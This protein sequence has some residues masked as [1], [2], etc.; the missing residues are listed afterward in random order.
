MSAAIREKS[1]GCTSTNFLKCLDAIS[2]LQESETGF[3]MADRKCSGGLLSF[4][5]SALHCCHV[6][7]L[8][9]FSNDCYNWAGWVVN[10]EILSTC[11]LKHIAH[12]ALWMRGNVRFSSRGSPKAALGG[13]LGQSPILWA[14]LDSSVFIFKG[15]VFPQVYFVQIIKRWSLETQPICWEFVISIFTRDFCTRSVSTCLWSYIVILCLFY[16]HQT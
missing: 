8:V 1:L 16:V 9:L 4:F 15:K 3:V 12:P 2:R 11:F 6:L 10:T 14:C 13:S 5:F 7:L